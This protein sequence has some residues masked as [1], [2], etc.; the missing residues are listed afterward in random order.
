M[1]QLQK[2]TWLIDTIRRAGYI[3]LNELSD[4]WEQWQ[5]DR[6]ESDCQ[7]LHRS[8]FNRWRTAIAD[9]FGID[10]ECQ[11]SGD[12]LYYIGNPDEIDDDKLKK[13]MLDSFALGNVIGENLSLK[14]RILIDEIPSGRT[15]LATIIEAMGENKTVKITYRPYS[16][17]SNYTFPIEPYCVKLFE[18]RWYVLAHNVCYDDLRLY[19]IDRIEVAEITA[20]KFKMPK[21]FDAAE[22]FSSSYGIIVDPEVEPRRIVLRADRNHKHYLKSLP[23]HHSQRLIE[24]A[25]EYADFELYLSPTYDFVMKLLQY[26]A[27]IEVISPAN[28]RKTMKGWISDMYN[29]YKND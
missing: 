2:Y 5:Q 16:K 6:G 24:D 17:S 23:L 26:G 13:W 27:M 28:L 10:I 1:N 4:R 8:T 25:G 21:D 18:N 11:H 9:Q 15:H 29:L 7:P 3:S 19:A 22:H 20:T 12:Y 14:G